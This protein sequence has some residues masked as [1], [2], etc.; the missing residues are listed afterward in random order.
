MFSKMSHLGPH[1]FV[2][3]DHHQRGPEWLNHFD[4]DERHRLVDE[5]RNARIQVLTVLVA[6]MVSGMSMLL[7]VVLYPLLAG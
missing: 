6:C 2:S 5:D 4:R 3:E 7:A 1:T